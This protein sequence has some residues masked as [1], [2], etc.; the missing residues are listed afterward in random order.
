MAVPKSPLWKRAFNDVERRVSGPLSSVTS[1][2][3]FQSTAM[4]VGRVRRAVVSPV[5]AVAGFGLHLV[6]LPS[7]SEVRELRRELHDVQREVLSLR[8][9]EAQGEREAGERE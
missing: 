6:G 1:S 3:E 2:T 8:R 4:R 7:K 9:D 5:H